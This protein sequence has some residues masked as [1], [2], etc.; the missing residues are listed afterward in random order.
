MPEMKD[1]LTCNASM[2]NNLNVYEIAQAQCTV[3]ILA[4][5]LVLA[6]VFEFCQQ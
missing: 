5:V 6:V 2:K 4:A 1:N 3:F